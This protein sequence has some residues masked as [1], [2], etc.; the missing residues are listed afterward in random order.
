MK[1]YISLKICIPLRSKS[2]VIIEDQVIDIFERMAKLTTE[3]NR[4]NY[5]L[6]TSMLYMFLETF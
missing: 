1:Q 2:V 3:F 4:L 6:T 5:N